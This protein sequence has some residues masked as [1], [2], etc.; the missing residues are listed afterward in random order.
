MSS[1]ERPDHHTRFKKGQSGNPSGRPRGRKSQTSLLRDVLFK[2]IRIKDNQTVRMLP[3]I[4]VAAEVCLNKAIKG[5]VRSFAKIM[6]LAQKF[7]LFKAGSELA[8]VVCIRRIIVYP[9]GEGPEQTDNPVPAED[10]KIDNL[11]LD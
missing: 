3:K 8:D 5:D 1:D 4:M 9:N 7:E 10:T 6:E 11:P 2:K